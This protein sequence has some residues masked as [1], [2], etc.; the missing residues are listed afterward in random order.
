[1]PLPSFAE[2][3]L[4]HHRERQEFEKKAVEKSKQQWAN[5]WDLVFT[6]KSGA[7]LNSSVVCH[8]F[9]KLLAKAGLPKKRFYDLRHTSASLLFDA[10][11]DM[12]DV[13]E[14]LRH[15]QITLT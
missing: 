10:G 2:D 11:A 12:L 5:D 7:P 6:T 13:K 8:Q 1:M 14:H 3:A 4:V 9:Q 15:S